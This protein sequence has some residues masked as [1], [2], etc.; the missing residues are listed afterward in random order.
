MFHT[1]TLFV[2]KIE[3]SDDECKIIYSSVGPSIGENEF[4]TY[5][6]AYSWIANFGHSFEMFSSS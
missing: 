4:Q 1:E 6:R 2:G 5:Y 3:V